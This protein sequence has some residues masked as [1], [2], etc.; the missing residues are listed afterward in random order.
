MKINEIIKIIDA[1]IVS[2]NSDRLLQNEEFLNAFASDLMSDVLRINSENTILI[3]GL[4]NIQTIR[5]AEMAD[6]KLVIL[7]RGKIADNAMLDLAE[8]NDICIVETDYSVFRVSGELFKANIIP[9][10]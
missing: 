4:C 2:N 10:Y 5:T 8:E 1:R 3:T 6:I 9:I 7:S